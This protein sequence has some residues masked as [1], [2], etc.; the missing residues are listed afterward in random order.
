MKHTKKIIAVAYIVTFIGAILMI[1]SARA[2]SA[3]E[4]AA[5]YGAYYG[6]SVNRNGSRSVTGDRVT[7]KPQP[8]NEGS[9][10]YFNSDTGRRGVITDHS[11]PGYSNY[12]IRE[13]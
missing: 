3:G 1:E 10:T 13:Y 12:T 6:Q 9:Y 8:G 5:A 11:T 4:A 2:G 7:I